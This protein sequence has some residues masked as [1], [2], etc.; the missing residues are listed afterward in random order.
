MSNIKF[1]QLP[2]LTTITGTTIVPVVDSLTNYTVTTANLKS[3]I[4]T[5]AGAITATSLSATGNVTGAYILGNGSLLTGLPAT[6]GNADVAAYLPTYTGNLNSVSAVPGA[7]ITGTVAN[8]TYAISAGS[9]STATSA[10]SVAGANVVGTVANAT[11]ATSAGSAST[12]TSATTAGTVTTAAQANITSVGT[13]TSLSATGNIVGGN[14]TTAGNV[15]GAYVKGNGSVLTG[16][17]TSIVAGSGIS[18]DQATGAVTVTAT[19]GGGAGNA[20]SYGNT[21]VDIPVSAG[22]ISFNVGGLADQLKLTNLSGPAGFAGAQFNTGVQVGNGTNNSQLVAYGNVVLSALGTGYQTSVDGN[23][24]VALRTTTS[25]LTVNS[26][27]TLTGGGTVGGNLSISGGF[28]GS[29]QS[30]RA[31][32]SSGI[33]GQIS[34]DANYIYVCTAANT[35]KR[36]A[37][38]SF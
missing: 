12:A 16:I 36:V 13:L 9:A 3:F 21:S 33:A 20:I 14:V 7:A 24:N 8:A 27:A 1:S 37:L 15:Q 29:A 28:F 22:N 5:G 4:T 25:Y 19:G 31:N 10:N 2:N 38:S 35:W 17:V 30:T 6:Y 23:L 34:V 26:T 11:Y 18:I 32:N